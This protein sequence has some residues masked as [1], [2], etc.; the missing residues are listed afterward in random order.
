MIGRLWPYIL[1][2]VA[3]G[4]DAYVIAGLLP[5]IAGDLDAE[6]GT[7]GLGVAAFTAAYAIA[8]PL[9]AGRAGRQPRRGLIAAL[10][11]FTLANVGTALSPAAW[12]FLVARLIAG[13][14]AGV[15]SPLASAVA[16]AESGPE[17]RGRALSLVLSGLALGTVAGVPIGMLLAEA[18]SWRGT[19]LLVTAVGA[20]ALG[21]IALRR[22][23]PL[24]PIPAS[25]AGDRLRMLARRPNLLTVLVTLLTA[26]A[27]LGLY[28]YA[29]AVISRTALA[30]ST[31]SAL[32]IWGIGGA[33]GAFGVG[34]LVDR[35]HRPMRLTLAI[36]LTL[37]LTLAGVAIGRPLP[38]LVIALAA[39]GM[40]GWAS[41]APQQHTLLS[42]NP[43]DGATAVAANASANY[44]GAAIGSAGGAALLAAGADGAHLALAAAGAAVLAAATQALRMGLGP[45]PAAA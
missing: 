41:L 28:T 25:S 10:A 45:H 15:Y 17:R 38:L 2:G 33:I 8:G 23:H 39:W 29:D 36:T 30:G 20:V 11:V 6:P 18:A 14:A 31:T 22:G 34:H 37:A 16:V 3:L 26:V 1:G 35:A 21:G 32:W 42:A 19:M 24:A 27:S 5:R 7:I 4:L 44:L 13:A 12:M 9:L 40:L 43:D